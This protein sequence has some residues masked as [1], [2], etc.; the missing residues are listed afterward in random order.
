VV[1]G[2]PRHHDRLLRL[3]AVPNE[4]HAADRDY[5]TPR[6]VQP[7]TTPGV[8]QAGLSCPHDGGAIWASG[9]ADCSSPP[10]LPT[11]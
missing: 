3:R 7:A 1:Q 5:E 4:R 11:V 6:R 2:Q 10:R 8:M 9:P